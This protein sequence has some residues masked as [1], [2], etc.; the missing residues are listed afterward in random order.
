MSEMYVRT[1]NNNF[2]YNINE[3]TDPCPNEEGKGHGEPQWSDVWHALRYSHH[4][5]YGYW[6][7]IIVVLI[8]ESVMRKL[9][10]FLICFATI[11]I[12]GIA[13]VA[14][15]QLLPVVA[16]VWTPWWAWNVVFGIFLLFSI[17]FNYV[18]AVITPAGN[19]NSKEFIAEEVYAFTADIPDMPTM[20]N[21]GVMDSCQKC[22]AY[23]P[24]R[25]H[26][27]SVCKS[28]VIKMDHHC[29][30]LNNCVGFGN[31]R[32][33]FSFLFYVFS[34]TL[35]I[36]ILL[37]P[38]INSNLLKPS[39]KQ[40]SLIAVGPQPSAH[41][42]HMKE[43]EFGRFA[44]PILSSQPQVE[45]EGFVGDVVT[46]IKVMKAIVFPPKEVQAAQAMAESLRAESEEV[47]EIL[48]EGARRRADAPLPRDIDH[49]SKVH[50]QSDDISHSLK[51]HN[52]NSA[53]EVVTAEHEQDQEQLHLEKENTGKMNI[54]EIMRMMRSGGPRE[55]G[56]S[57]VIVFAICFAVILSV[58]IL[59]GFHFY[60][61]L[62]N[63][64][65]LEFFIH[66][67]NSPGSKWQN[68]YNTGTRMGNYRAV[69]GNV[70]WYLSLLPSF[71]KPPPIKVLS[72]DD[73]KSMFSKLENTD[74]I[75]PNEAKD[76]YATARELL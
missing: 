47:T 2:E 70:P 39:D 45:R 43:G 35:Y 19:P 24:P 60:L 21:K 16:D 62:K 20:R 56:R 5:N 15:F 69:F 68:P 31:Y 3:N 55:T 52:S 50:L 22:T 37:C 6:L 27:C 46:T 9:G 41:Y 44:N 58:G 65:T 12:T 51:P 59:G 4:F 7:H 61:I 72:Y 1:F 71:R 74:E 57:M 73:F 76:L 64:T 13:F 53:D 26:H 34:A 42:G 38:H 28:C 67:R 25:V 29:P 63:M 11:L 14:L 32:Y 54:P 23:K 40:M 33:F 75:G 36:A 66:M 17:Y 30:W 8:I 18:M 48:H 49:S 10:L